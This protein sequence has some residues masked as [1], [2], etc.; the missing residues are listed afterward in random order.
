MSEECILLKWFA[1]EHLPENLQ[2]VSAH[3]YDLAIY[4]AENLEN[5]PEQEVCLRKLVEAK[6]AAVRAAVHPGG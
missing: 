1:Y 2:E 3:F 5:G 6:D 4:I